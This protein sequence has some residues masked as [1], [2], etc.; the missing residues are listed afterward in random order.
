MGH[1][2]DGDA[3]CSWCSRNNLQ[4]IGKRTERRGNQRTSGDQPDYNIIKISQNTEKT[5]RD[6]RSLAVIQ[7]PV[8]NHQLTLV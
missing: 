3:N 1:E 6:L 2:G 7:T 8:E 5:P 4:R